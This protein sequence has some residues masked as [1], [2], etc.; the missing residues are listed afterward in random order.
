MPY[1][2]DARA[3]MLSNGKSSV[4]R[5][6]L[7]RRVMRLLCVP[8]AARSNR[9]RLPASDPRIRELGRLIEDD[10]A[11]LRSNYDKPKNPIVLAHGLFGFD[12]LHLAGPRLPGIQYWRGIIE[13][14]G[15]KGIECFTATVPP[16]G[17]IE[18]RAEKLRAY[19]QD[20][21]AGRNVNIIA[22]LDSRY[23]ISQLKPIDPKIVSLTTI[24]SPHRG[25]A[26]ADY[27]LKQIGPLNIPKVYKVLE[28]FGLESGAFSQL[29]QKYMNEEF[30]PKTPNDPNVRYYSYGAAFDPGWLSMFRQSHA[31]VERI[32]GLNDGLV[33]VKSSQWGEYKG[34]LNGVS[35]LD[36][37]NWT[38]RL[39]WFLFEMS[40]GHRNFNAVAL[41]LDIA[42][43]LA[44][45]GL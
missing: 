25:S 44:K 37:I 31:I 15:A 20:K 23:M 34:T 30:N 28:F 33:S 7:E 27:L 40:G 41:Y 32:E 17:S 12:Q 26:F 36:L 16:S 11:V 6:A 45:E 43:M 38:N 42:D 9:T 3:P 5:T 29:T 4:S 1:D 10:Y 14:L 2:Q 39:R 21:A 13:A 19:I 22:G 18:A 8:H 35:H 24:A